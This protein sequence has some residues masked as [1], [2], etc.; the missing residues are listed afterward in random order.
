[1]LCDFGFTYACWPR[2]QV[3]AN[4][5]F[6]FAQARTGEFDGGCQSLDRLVLAK[7]DPLERFFKILENLCVV[8]GDVFGWD[9]RDFGDNSFDFFHADG[10]TA[11]ALW[12][13]VLGCTRFVD[14]VNRL[15]GQFAVIDIARGKLHSRADRVGGVFDAVMLLEVRFQAAQDFDR[16]F[17]RW[18]IHVDFLETTGK[19][20]VF[21]KV[22][23]EFFVCGRAHTAQ[24]AAL[25]RRLQQVR[26]IHRT[27][28]CGARANDCVDFVD[29]KHGVRV[30]FH[31][32]DHGFQTL[33]KVAAIAGARKQ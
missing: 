27:A 21:F 31:F 33:F 26:G 24:F 9:A 8:F 14:D 11:L 22:L 29:E 25:K 2:E 28:R 20:A 32:G 6:R 30:R 1:M 19:R 13:Q 7:D 4:R 5:L 16:I 15:V 17:D 3:V 12:D 10:F 18:L 23:A